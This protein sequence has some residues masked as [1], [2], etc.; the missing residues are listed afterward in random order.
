MKDGP[1]IRPLWA[2][3]IEATQPQQVFYVLAETP[4]PYL[5]GRWERKL[6]TEVRGREATACYSLLSRAGFRRSHHFAY[7][8]ACSDCRAC[9]PVRVVVEGF[10]C[11]DSLK[12]VLRLNGDL[13]ESFRPNRANEEQYRVFNRYIG[14]RHGDGE[15]A[16]MTYADY[17]A[18]VERTDLDTEVVEYRDGDGQLLAACLLDWLIDGPSAVYSFF[19]PT[20]A[21]RSLGSLMILKLI[22]AARRRGTAF[23]YLGYWVSGSP[24][25]AYKTRFRPLEIF[26]NGGW[27]KLPETHTVS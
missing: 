20:E 7:R 16:G 18:M 21:R 26:G 1:V 25:M 11:T 13:K 3:D 9:V 23:V 8:P 6:M 27:R 19:D 17:R 4:C 10:R 22:E 5:P 2:G 24:K 15:M 14:T 12:R